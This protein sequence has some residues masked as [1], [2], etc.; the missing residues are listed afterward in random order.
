MSEPYIS[1]LRTVSQRQNW[2]V[3]REGLAAVILDNDRVA[4]SGPHRKGRGCVAVRVSENLVVISAYCSPNK[5]LIEF[6]RFLVE[7]GALV[8]W[9]RPHDIIVAGDFNAKSAAWGTVDD[10]GRGRALLRWAA[11]YNLT[12]LNKGSEHTCVRRAGGSIV[13]VTFAS[14]CLARRVEDWEVM[15]KVETLSDHRYIQF[16]I[17]PLSCIAPARQ[18]LIPSEIGPRWSL[19]SLDRVVFEEATIVKS[20]C[21]G[22]IR[23]ADIENEVRWYTRALADLSD[24]SMSRVRVLRPR[25]GVYWWSDELAVLRSFCVRSRRVFTR[26]RRRPQ[27][28]R[29]QDEEERLYVAYQAAKR[30]LR[31]AMAR[32]KEEAWNG[33]LNTLQEDPWGRP[34][35]LVMSKLRPRAPPLTSS[36]QPSLLD[37]VVATLFPGGNGRTPA[38]AHPCS[39]PGEE[40]MRVTREELDAALAKVVAKNTA[41]GP[42]GLHGRVWA[43]ALKD[44]EMAWRF[45]GLLTRIMQKGEFPSAWKTGK[46]VLIKKPSKAE[47][48]PSAYRPIICTVPSLDSGVRG[49]LCAE[50]REISEETTEQGGVAMAVSLD[51]ANAFNTIPH[52][53]ILRGLVHHGIPLYLR[54]LVESYLLN[55]RIVF[56]G[57]D[58]WRCYRVTCGVPQGSVLGPLLWNIGY[59]CILQ[60]SLPLGVRVICYA[61]DT[62]VVASGGTY[63]EASRRVTA[64]VAQVVAQIRRLGLRVALEKSEAICFHGP[65][66]APP[67]GAHI[68]VAGVSIEVGKSLKYLGLV[69][70]SRWTFRSHFAALAP[71]LTATSLALSR[72]MPNLG[73]PSEGCRQLYSCV[74]KSQAL[75]GCPV[76]ADKLSRKNKQLLRRAQKSILIRVARAYRTV[77]YDA[78]C[79]IAGSAPWHL[80]ATA[81]ADVY[82]RRADAREAGAEPATE[83][84]RSWRLDACQ[85]V[86]LDWRAEFD[87]AQMG[88]YTVSAI[89][90]VLNEWLERKR[91]SLTFRLVQV[92]SGH[93]CFG[94][95]LHRIRREPTSAC[96][97]CQEL[98]D[99]AA[100][101]LAACP[102]WAEERR[103][104]VAAFGTDLSLSTIIKKAVADLE[105]WTVLSTYCGVVM[106]CKE[107]AERAREVYVESS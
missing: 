34:F 48:S 40:S 24:V 54:R 29:S 65:R 17:P 64:G 18:D 93:G 11:M 50:V 90:P 49:Q 85:R 69:L 102:A 6:E 3:D 16:R 96:H 61:D 22:P 67:A 78:V 88:R 36:M 19:R 43:L 107:Q 31:V 92:I 71:K 30:D 80:E 32:A 33:F 83:T 10:R 68:V 28:R 94:K 27:T 106:L 39:I 56:P 51:I 77:S 8:D 101:T 7:I 81:L 23:N 98:V 37:S 47:T 21:S 1:D 89:L 104:L 66:R 38:Q 5:T 45:C 55:R 72:I 95:Y 79:L 26:Y 52:E 82:W 9:A 60:A 15:T 99:D 105:K 63:V 87:G 13:D 86:I 58:A 100:H 42:D 97:H 14:S 74:V 46:L 62:L 76:W 44:E 57:R 20:W 84:I 73:G 91:G 103:N 12:V 59:N 35:R 41:P 25:N 53:A 2:I 70:D 4:L 75:Y